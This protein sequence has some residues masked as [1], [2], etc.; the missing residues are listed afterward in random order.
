M[1]AIELLRELGA[2]TLA[3]SIAVLLVV[4]VSGPL[5]RRCGAGAAYAL[6]W[7]VP[8][9]MLA[10]LLPARTVEVPVAVM[11]MLPS[12]AATPVAGLAEL[13]AAAAA[14]AGIGWAGWALVAWALVATGVLLAGLRVQR[15]FEASLGTL[16]RREDGLYESDAIEGLPAVVGWRPRIVLAA[17]F[18]SRY[19]PREQALV[20]AHERT[21]LAR[22]DLWINALAG[23][24]CAIQWF[25][26]LAWWA[27]RRFRVAQE[28]ACDAAVL[29][30]VP[31]QRRSYGEALLKTSVISSPAPLAC[32]WPGTHPL[33]ER[34]KM[35]EAGLPSRTRRSIGRVAVAGFVLACSAGA[36]AMQAPQEVE[37]VQA[38][39]VQ[40]ERANVTEGVHAA[41]DRDGYVSASVNWEGDR[42][43]RELA[44]AT[45]RTLEIDEGV[46]GWVAI[47]LQLES[48]PETH[49][50]MIVEDSTPGVRIEM[51]DDV[52]RVFQAA[53]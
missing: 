8:L 31:G 9:A 18:A 12:L 25:N 1:D 42:I 49:V 37:A 20:L 50:A 13:P 46:T 40:P 35:L 5:R 38:P 6:W 28:L 29:A 4:L 30:A 22:G 2:L 32:R 10:V 51:D 11:P 21:H 48:V 44:R 17:D 53:E 7:C 23:L 47:T 16:R 45:G 14:Q 34:L 15:R 52:I 24:L 39:Q 41:P 33:K 26:P 43:L 27:L 36:W 19:S 3:G